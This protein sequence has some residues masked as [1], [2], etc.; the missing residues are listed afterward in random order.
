MTKTKKI[1][2]AAAVIAALIIAVFVF[3]I[4]SSSQAAHSAVDAYNTA[5]EQYNARIDTYNTAVNGIA[6]ENEELQ[7][8]MDR[9]EADIKNDAEAYEPDT[10]EDL[11]DELEKA[12]K[13]P[14][15][16]PALIDPFDAMTVSGGFS[17]KE[18]ERQKQEAEASLAAVREAEKKIPETP[19]VPDFSDAKKKL[20]DKCE[21][22]EKSVQKLKNVTAPSESFVTERLSK[23]DTVVQTGAVTKENDPNGLLGKKGGY[24]ACIYFLDKRVDRELLPAEA[25]RE[26]DDPDDEEKAEAGATDSEAAEESKTGET[27]SETAEESKTGETGAETAEESKTGETGAETAEESKTGETGAETAEESKTGETG[28]EKAEESMTGSTDSEAAEESITGSTKSETAKEAGTGETAAK[29]AE[30]EAPKEKIDVVMIGTAGGGAVEVFASKK[31][32]KERIEYLEFFDGSVM[33][34]GSYDLE[35]TCVI[36]TSKHLSEEDQK[37]LTKAVREALLEVD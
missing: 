5:A 12:K 3:S 22:Y 4:W 34:A 17:K 35:G 13:L 15:Q 7:K 26:A 28:A 25:F 30:E 14:V 24:T 16:V 37:K 29:A 19:A 31:D 20:Q 18:F 9:A 36:R 23:V 27:G 33:A 1:A 32:A 11:Q 8:V 6:S 21:E 2:A 10:K